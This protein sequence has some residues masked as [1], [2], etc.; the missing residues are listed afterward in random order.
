MPFKAEITLERK[1]AIDHIIKTL[2]KEKVDFGE[3]P[4]SSNKQRVLKKAGAEKLCSA[5]GLAPKILV[6]AKV[7]DWTGSDHDGEP[8]FEY[9]YTLGLFK[10]DRCFGEATA[11]CNSWEKKYRYHWISEE[12]V[13]KKCKFLQGLVQTESVTRELARLM[14][15]PRRGGKKIMFEP[16]WAL[17]KRETEGKYGKP[18]EYW[19]R[20]D[21][22]IEKGKAIQTEKKL[23]EKVHKGWQITI[24][25]TLVQIP[26]PNAADTVNTVQ[27]M[28]YKRAFVAVTVLVTNCSDAFTQD[29]DDDEPPT[30]E[31][32][33]SDENVPGSPAPEPPPT[34]GHSAPV[35]EAV[36]EP[37]Q[38]PVGNPTARVVPEEMTDAIARIRKD[39]R[40]LKEMWN[41]MWSQFSR[42]GEEAGR[43][44]ETLNQKFRNRFP[45]GS[46]GSRDIENHVNHLLDLWDLLQKY[47]EPTAAGQ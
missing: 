44:M 2:L 9:E 38:P 16:H 41:M 8:F 40:Q 27:K 22:L 14:N 33:P 29:L 24:D 4:G 10:G 15:A 6:E 18:V 30:V 13:A 46:E 21:E 5:F 23:G 12:E 19:N 1:K 28:A 11:S 32:G 37:S 35:Q 45:K 17:D 34:R 7:K 42:R 47:P 43:A 20:F 36:V 3:Q 39:P 31:A 26:N 25:E